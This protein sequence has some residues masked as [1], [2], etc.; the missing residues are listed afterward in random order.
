MRSIFFFLAVVFV[1]LRSGSIIDFLRNLGSF[2]YWKF[3]DLQR[4]RQNGKQRSFD[5]YGVRV[6]C[7][8]QGAGKTVSLVWMLDDIKRRFPKAKIYTNFSYQFADGQLESLNDLLEY[9]NGQD[10]VVFAIDELQNEFSSK[11]SKDFPEALLS[12]ITMQR[13]QKIC[14]LATTQVF[15]RLAKPLREQCFQVFECRTFFGR[16]T[17]IRGYDAED[18]NIFLDSTDEKKKWKVHRNYKK[19]FIQTDRLRE[20]YDTMEVI[21]R[22]SRQ[23]F[24]SKLPDGSC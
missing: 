16:W 24:A 13:K 23:G 20:S 19:S 6:F 5:L 2:A 10:G 12:T 4:F 14:I 1:L 7:G 17:R 3:I 15:S 11:V 9:R 8:R 22:L 21:Q 18:Y